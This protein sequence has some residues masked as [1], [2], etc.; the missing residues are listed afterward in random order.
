VEVRQLGALAV[1]EARGLRAVDV[2]QLGA[3]QKVAR[4]EDDAPEAAVVHMEL[5]FRHGE[6]TVRPLVMPRDQAAL[7]AA[8]IRAIIKERTK[9]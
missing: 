9:T 3:L 8:T 6:P 5:R 1:R 2:R 4:A 7:L